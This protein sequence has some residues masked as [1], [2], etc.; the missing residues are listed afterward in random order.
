MGLCEKCLVKGIPKGDYT[1][2]LK[3]KEYALKAMAILKQNTET[4]F[5]TKELWGQL[6]LADKRHNSQMD[7]V[8]ALWENGLI[9]K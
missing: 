7:V 6:E 5:S 1:K 8:L 9:V 3:N 4:T 2:S